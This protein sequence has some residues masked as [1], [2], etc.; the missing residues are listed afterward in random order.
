MV[1]TLTEYTKEE[2]RI[3][4][5]NG[6]LYILKCPQCGAEHGSAMSPDLLP[7]LL[8]CFGTPTHEDWVKY[9]KERDMTNSDIATIVGLTPESVKNQTAPSKILPR[10]AVSML[11]EWITSKCIY[12]G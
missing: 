11:Y 10:W 2:S 1:H 12:N 4:R 8:T 6:S 7:D 9:K 5:V 3:E